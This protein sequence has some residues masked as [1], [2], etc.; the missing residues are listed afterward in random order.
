MLDLG[1]YNSLQHPAR[2]GQATGLQQDPDAKTAT[3]TAPRQLQQDWS[4]ARSLLISSEA[5]RL[6]EDFGASMTA[7][8]QPERLQRET[9]EESGTRTT[10][11]TRPWRP[12]LD[13]GAGHNSL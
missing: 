2:I 6:Q 4:K 1:S 5:M 9:T 13:S 10:A 3:Y 7:H 12:R 8:I 11:H